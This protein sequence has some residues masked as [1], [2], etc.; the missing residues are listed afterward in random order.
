M[1]KLNLDIMYGGY[2]KDIHVYAS[3]ITLFLVNIKI[4]IHWRWILRAA[5]RNFAYP[6]KPIPEKNSCNLPLFEL[7]TTVGNF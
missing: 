3:V 6:T 1:M 5:R 2:W 7:T 4:G